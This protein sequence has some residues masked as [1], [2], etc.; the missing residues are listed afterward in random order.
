MKKIKLEEMDGFRQPTPEEI[1]M[2]ENLVTEEQQKQIQFN[3]VVTIVFA[4]LAIISFLGIFAGGISAVILMVIFAVI[5]YIPSREYRYY[6]R[7]I[8]AVTSG[9]FRVIDGL[10]SEIAYSDFPGDSNVRFRTESGEYCANWFRIPNAGLKINTPILI[11]H[12]KVNRGMSRV[13][14]KERKE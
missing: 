6:Q 4:V 2:F 14:R 9:K 8:D 7:E 3:K 5:A 11:A 10:V 12:I 13:V 1:S